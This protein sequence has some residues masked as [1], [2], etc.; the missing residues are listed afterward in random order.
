M[1]SAPDVRYGV[2]VALPHAQA[3]MGRPNKRAKTLKGGCAGFRQGG[4]DLDRRA[5]YCGGQP[6]KRP[7]LIAVT[8]ERFRSISGFIEAA[9]APV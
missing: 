3:C 1:N 7:T 9:P 5:A 2:A 8:F 6:S 4:F